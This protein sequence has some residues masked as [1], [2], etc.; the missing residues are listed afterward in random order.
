[1]TFLGSVTYYEMY[2]LFD[3]CFLFIPT[4]L[5]HICDCTVTVC[6]EAHKKLSILQDIHKYHIK[7][8]SDYMHFLSSEISTFCLLKADFFL[9]FTWSLSLY[10]LWNKRFRK[11]VLPKSCVFL[12][13]LC[14]SSMYF[15]STF[16]R[17]RR[18]SLAERFAFKGNSLMWSLTTQQ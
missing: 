17:M 13:S 10:H 15:K 18:S 2:V 8:T 6:V 3:H 7:W 12:G 5:M 4:L 16:Y 11:Y 9:R 1:M 14:S